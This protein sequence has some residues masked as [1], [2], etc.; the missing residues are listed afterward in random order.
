MSWIVNAT[1]LLAG[2]ACFIALNLI[3]SY[4]A[5]DGVLH[6]PFALIPIGYLLSFAGILG[7]LWRIA[8]NFLQERSH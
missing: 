3:G 4:V 1:L 8:L 5:K 6:E 7:T 2:I